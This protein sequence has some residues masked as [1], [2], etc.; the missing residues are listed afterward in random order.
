MLAPRRRC[1]CDLVQLVCNRDGLL[2]RKQHGCQQ[3]LHALPGYGCG[4]RVRAGALPRP[5]VFNAA[6]AAPVQAGLCTYGMACLL[7]SVLPGCPCSTADA[8]G[9]NAAPRDALTRAAAAPHVLLLPAAA[10]CSVDSCNDTAHCCNSRVTHCVLQHPHGCSSS[11]R[12]A[13]VPS[14]PATAA[15]AVGPPCRRA[16]VRMPPRRDAL[17]CPLVESPPGGRSEAPQ[18]WAAAGPRR[19]AP[20]GA[21][22]RNSRCPRPPAAVPGP[23]ARTWAT[24]S[25]S[26]L[27]SAPPSFTIFLRAVN[28]VATVRRTAGR[29]GRQG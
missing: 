29:A 18:A 23:P 3:M 11:R 14:L 24:C 4:P 6:A 21:A 10:A 25:S 1:T 5:A 19:Q 15:S 16:A 22:S 20:W 7:L 9:L 27:G 17:H 12:A 8:T 13:L 28:I 26:S 2:L